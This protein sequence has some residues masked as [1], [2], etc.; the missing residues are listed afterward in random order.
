LYLS[1]SSS[2]NQQKRA[3]FRLEK[4]AGRSPGARAAL[5]VILRLSPDAF[6]FLLK[7]LKV[8]TQIGF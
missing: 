2:V 1:A 8:I 6:S 5:E 7:R 3:A 4:L